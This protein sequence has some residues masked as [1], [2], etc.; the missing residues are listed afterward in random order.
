MGQQ[1]VLKFFQENKRPVTSK[2]IILKTKTN[3]R[4]VQR[5]LL[6]MFK[7]GEVKRIRNK[8]QY[9]YTLV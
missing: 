8:K 3:R 6:M 7:Y 9:I 2:E 5:A 1:E 4:N